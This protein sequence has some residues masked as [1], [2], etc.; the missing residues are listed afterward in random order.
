LLLRGARTGYDKNLGICKRPATIWG[1][2]VLLV[3]FP[4]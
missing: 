3:P 2:V 1:G 4:T